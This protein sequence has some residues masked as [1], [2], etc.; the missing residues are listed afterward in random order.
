[1]I[2]GERVT[3]RMMTKD[4]I[5]RQ[6]EFDQDP[7]LYT[8]DGSTI[9]PALPLARTEA[10]YESRNR[11]NPDEF[12]P[13]AV[14]ADGK[15]IGSVELGHIDRREGTCELGIQIGR[16]DSSCTDV[17]WLGGI[18]FATR[19][20]HCN[21]AVRIHAGEGNVGLDTKA[22]AAANC[23]RVVTRCSGGC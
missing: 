16:G 20:T 13:L 14:E 1:M 8:L 18:D 6:H 23:V 4:D 19:L 9:L 21:G 12:V 2:K 15:Y 17:S 7:E 22:V 3:L 5:P 11:M 10:F